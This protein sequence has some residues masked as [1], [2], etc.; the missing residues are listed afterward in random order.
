[1]SIL[2]FPRLF[3]C[4]ASVNSSSKKQRRALVR[5][6][7]PVLEALE[8][9]RL[10]S[11]SGAATANAG[12]SYTMALKPDLTATVNNWSVNW[13]DSGSSQTY[14]G[15]PA[16]ASHSYM[17]TGNF[18]PVATANYSGG[19]STADALGL[20]T[21]FANAASNGSGN[22]ELITGLVSQANIANGI[23]VQSDG[24]TIVAGRSTT[25][26]NFTLMR[27]NAD[28]SIDTH[29]GTG[30]GTVTTAFTYGATD[31][32][33]LA[34]TGD[35]SAGTLKI[36]ASGFYGNTTLNGGYGSLGVARF[37]ANGTLDTTFNPSGA[38]PGMIATDLT[39]NQ[40]AVG[41]TVQGTGKLLIGGCPIVLSGGSYV[42]GGYTIERYNTNGTLD[43]SFATS[44][45]L[46]T[47]YSSYYASFANFQSNGA[48]L[49]IGVESPS[50]AFVI[51]KYSVDG[52]LDTTFGTSGAV[53]TGFNTG[54]DQAYL[55]TIDASSRIVAGGALWN[56]G[57]GYSTFVLKRYTS[58]G[59]AD[60]DFRQR[61]DCLYIHSPG[62][63][64]DGQYRYPAGQQDRDRRYLK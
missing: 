48:I 51:H 35:P 5:A 18:K 40:S 10:M 59:A 1:M 54:D 30:G 37:N 24:K 56:S 12:I 47:I 32:L 20:D 60:F 7:R 19:A 11:A 46:T 33:S 58:A 61:R 17:T 41:L 44:G 3:G 62:E 34:V 55:V 4:G 28:G 21:A 63:G 29:F 26:G 9:R 43:T 38:T 14:T 16:T 27:Y 31:V 64:L 36:Y 25:S 57:V 52:V 23:A 22:G 6:T 42:G 8:T 15:N 45:K 53:S 50:Y 13:G 49:T 2:N 39:N